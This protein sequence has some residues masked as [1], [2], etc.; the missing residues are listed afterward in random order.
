MNFLEKLTITRKSK[1]I[2]N[3]VPYLVRDNPRTELT[4]FCLN[5]ETK[6]SNSRYKINRNDQYVRR[7]VL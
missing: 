4:D 5:K 1:Q 7:F 2:K 3:I 6:T